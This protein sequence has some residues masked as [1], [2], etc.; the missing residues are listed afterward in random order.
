MITNKHSWSLG[1]IPNKSPG[2]RAFHSDSLRSSDLPLYPRRIA[3]IGVFHL[4]HII[5]TKQHNSF[6]APTRPRPLGIIN[7]QPESRKNRNLGKIHNICIERLPLVCPHRRPEGLVLFE[8]FHEISS[9]P[10]VISPFPSNFTR[11][12]SARSAK[13]QWSH[14]AADAAMERC[15]SQACL[16]RLR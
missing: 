1:S 9:K 11:E 4:L 3:L 15:A 6:K 12:I 10:P 8:K 5:Y 2:T 7:S 13:V 14:C 16:H